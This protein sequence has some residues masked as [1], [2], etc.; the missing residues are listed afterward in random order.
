MRKFSLVLLSLLVLL[1][2]AGCDAFMMRAEAAG[3]F[4]VKEQENPVEVSNSTFALPDKLTWL[5]PKT[6]AEPLPQEKSHG[7]KTALR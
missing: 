5:V 2:L 3:H 6:E 1:V 4:L 7:R